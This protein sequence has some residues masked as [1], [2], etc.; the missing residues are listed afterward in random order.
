MT[1]TENPSPVGRPREFD[2][3]AVLSAVIELFWEKGYGATS[4][5]DIVER[6][7]LSKSSLYGAF[8]S[9]DELYRT[10]LDRYLGDQ[11]AHVQDVLVN[12]TS[13]LDDIEAF[14]GRVEEQID[15]NQQRGCL[16]VNTATELHTGEPALVELGVAHREVMRRGFAAALCRAAERG[17]ID[18]ARIAD[19]ANTLVATAIG[20]AVMIRGGAPPSELRAHARSATAFLRT[21]TG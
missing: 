18:R 16:A 8:G 19:G 4:V 5:G 12:G 3:E 7:G 11:S 14:F 9:K 10:A 20:L 21:T 6:T 2:H 13:G 17:E 1:S 15:V